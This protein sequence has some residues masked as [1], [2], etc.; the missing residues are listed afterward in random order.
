MEI[1]IPEHWIAGRWWENRILWCFWIFGGV[2]S[3]SI[4]LDKRG[5]PW[6]PIIAFTVA[7]FVVSLGFILADHT[8]RR[9]NR[10]SGYRLPG[11]K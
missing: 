2:L 9:H 3:V 7:S 5:S 10:R 8:R 4:W 6:P 1:S 11:E